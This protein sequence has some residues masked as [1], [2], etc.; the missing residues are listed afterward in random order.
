MAALEKERNNHHQDLGALHF[1]NGDIG[2]SPQ[3]L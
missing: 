2:N 1:L 3:T